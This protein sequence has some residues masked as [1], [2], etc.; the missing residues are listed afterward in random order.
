[1]KIKNYD[2]KGK[3]SIIVPSENTF[4]DNSSSVI[5]FIKEINNLESFLIV[6]MGN[7]SHIDSNCINT[8]LGCKRYLRNRNID[9]A[10]CNLQKGPQ[11][12]LEITRAYEVLDVCDTHWLKS[13]EIEAQ[14]IA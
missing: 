3:V 8:L 1:M 14:K 9:F 13:Y 12:V 2:V 4:R 11:I 5:N 10:I 6:D 7:I